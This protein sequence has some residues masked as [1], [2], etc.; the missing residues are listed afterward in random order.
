LLTKHIDVN[1]QLYIETKQ[2]WNEK[3]E[4]KDLSMSMCC[5][6]SGEFNLLC[7]LCSFEGNKDDT[8]HYWKS[9]ARHA[10]ARTHKTNKRTCRHLFSRS[11]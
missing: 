6:W 4:K 10:N 11:L 3:S 2:K 1:N 8:I 7:Q 5:Y 9:P